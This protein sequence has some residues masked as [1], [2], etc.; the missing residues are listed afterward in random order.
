MATKIHKG[1]MIECPMCSPD[2][3]ESRKKFRVRKSKSPATL[4]IATRRQV[5]AELGEDEPTKDQRYILLQKFGVVSPK[6]D[7]QVTRPSWMSIQEW[8]RK[9]N[10]WYQATKGMVAPQQTRRPFGKSTRFNRTPNRTLNGYNAFGNPKS[11][12]SAR[13][14]TMALPVEIFRRNS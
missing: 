3:T 1:L 6:I 7:R 2:S 13:T 12:N 10:D 8:K 5:A 9:S 4:D 11:R 14:V